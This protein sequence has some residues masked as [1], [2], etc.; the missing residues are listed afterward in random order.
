MA[1]QSSAR[2]LASEKCLIQLPVSLKSI[3]K[4]VEQFLI[5]I[6]LDLNITEANCAYGS[7]IRFLSTVHRNYLLMV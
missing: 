7:T 1:S 6:N 4:T 5:L 3:Y 2:N